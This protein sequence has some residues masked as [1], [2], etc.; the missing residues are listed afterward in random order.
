MRGAEDYVLR[1]CKS[2]GLSSGALF[3]VFVVVVFL[4]GGEG[5]GVN[6]PKHQRNFINKRTKDEAV[7]DKLSASPNVVCR[8]RKADRLFLTNGRKCYLMF[9]S[10]CLFDHAQK[11]CFQNNV[12]IL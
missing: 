5:G 12:T 6:M 8:P 4:G 7:R 2:H 9:N 11:V 10:P 3:E 1:G